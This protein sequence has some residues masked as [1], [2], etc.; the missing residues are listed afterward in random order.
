MLAERFA[1]GI[2]AIVSVVDPA[3]VVLAGAVLTAGGERLRD[4]VAEQVASFAAA[5]PRV[6]LAAVRERPVLAGALQTAVEA[7]REEVFDTMSHRR[8]LDGRQHQLPVTSRQD[9]RTP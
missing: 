7:A 2:A 9:R 8:R 4:L 1:L 6:E 5:Q 3:L